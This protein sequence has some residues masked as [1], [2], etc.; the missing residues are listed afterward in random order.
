MGFVVFKPLRALLQ[1]RVLL[2]SLL[3]LGYLLVGFIYFRNQVFSELHKLFA[4][5]MIFMLSYFYIFQYGRV[6]GQ[7]LYNS[8]EVKIVPVEALDAGV[9]INKKYIEDIMGDRSNLEQFRQEMEQTL[10]KEEN[11]DLLKLIKNKT[12]KSHADKNLKQLL[13]LF[14]GLNPQSLPGLISQIY[15]FKRQRNIEKILL[16]KISGKLSDQQKKQ[17][18]NILKNS[19]DIKEFLKSVKGRLTKEQANELKQMIMQRNQEISQ[20][21][22][23][24]VKH[25]VL[26]KSFSFAPFM[27]FGVIITLVTK[28]SIIHLIYLYILH[29]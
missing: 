29:R 14:R 24:P 19:N 26:H 16:G 4:L 18:N 1:K 25:I 15:E 6:L 9:F 21:G 5:Q 10:E 17:L 3:I 22:F 28:S 12:D 23:Q 2:V 7:F 20:Q 11:E 27:L 8:A 13:S